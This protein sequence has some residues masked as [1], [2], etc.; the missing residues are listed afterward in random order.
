MQQYLQVIRDVLSRGTRKENR[1]GVDTLSTFGLHY[2]VDLRDGFPLLTTKRMPWKSVVM[3][4][5]WFL[6]GAS[7][8]GFLRKHGITFWDP[9]ADENGRIPSAYGSFWRN[10]PVHTPSGQPGVRDQVAWVLEELRR[11]PMSRRL[12]ISAWAPGNAMTSALPP[13]HLLFIFNVQ[14]EPCRCVCHLSNN[15]ILHDRACCNNGTER[16]LN[17]HLTQR[18]CDVT[19]G[20][21]FNL[22]GYAFLLE[23]FSRFSGLTAGRFSH[24]LVDAHIYTSKPDGSM[25]EYD[26]VPGLQEQLQ[27]EPLKLPKLAISNNIRSLEDVEKL[28]DADAGTIMSKFTLIG[29]DAHPGIQFRVAV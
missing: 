17:L 12:V 26:H 7:D 6:S 13:C 24:T 16:V 11:N 8:I 1:T 27:R 29:Y 20:L 21:P 15:I 28:Y 5:L 14:N 2:D 9:W 3:E 19:L 23:L 25:A 10:F 22:A 18:S 4:N